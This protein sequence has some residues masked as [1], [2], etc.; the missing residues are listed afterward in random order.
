MKTSHENKNKKKG[1]SKILWFY[2]A[3]SSGHDYL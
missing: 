2:Y 1:L 3:F